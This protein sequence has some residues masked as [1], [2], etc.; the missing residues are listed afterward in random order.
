MAFK[1]SNMDAKLRPPVRILARLDTKSDKVI[2]GIHLEGWR[3]VGDAESLCKKYYDQKAD[4]IILIDAVASL[5]NRE[6]LIQIIKKS[7]ENLFIPLTAGGGIKS[8]WDAEELFKSGADKVTI[9][10]GIVTNPNLIG[11]ISKN[12]GSQS[13]VVSIQAKKENDNWKVFYDSARE[14]TDKNILDWIKICQDLGAG[15]FLIT[16]IDKEGTEE[17]FDLQ[18]MEAV[19]EKSNIPIIA[20]GGFGKLSDLKNIFEFKNITGVAIANM[21][22]KNTLSI[23]DIKKYLLENKIHTRN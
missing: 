8:I 10:S 18:L 13:L 14:K 12:F 20:S 16:S 2:K 22:H 1:A 6:K 11:E 21:L 23:S 15:E 4:E 5:Y 17:G 7:A 9:N 3:I 19:S